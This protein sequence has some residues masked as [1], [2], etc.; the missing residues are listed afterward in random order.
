ML[1]YRTLFVWYNIVET[2]Y[3]EQFTK[4]EFFGYF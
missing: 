1:K 4:L 2:K 3:V